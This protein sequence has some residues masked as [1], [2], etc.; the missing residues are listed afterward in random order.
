MSS[1]IQASLPYIKPTKEAPI[2][3][4]GYPEL[5]NLHYDWQPVE[6]RSART[7]PGGASLKTHGFRAVKHPTAIGV[8]DESDTWHPSFLAEVEQLLKA[9][10]GASAVVTLGAAYRSVTLKGSFAPA[11][12]CHSDFTSVGAAMHVGQLDPE[13][14]DLRLAKRFAAYNV[15]RLVSGAPQDVPLA[16]CDARSVRSADVVPGKAYYGGPDNTALWGEMAMFR[17][18]PAHRWYFYPDLSNDEVL[19]WCGYDS[20]PAFASIVPHTAFS[21]PTCPTPVPPRANVECRCLAFF[22]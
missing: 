9:L 17:F 8:F 3:Y 1:P 11:S 14:A 7:I 16:L 20:D 22:D 12:F 19:I 15:W 18:N 13:L 10:T 4:A 21:D 2:S 6:I 5:E